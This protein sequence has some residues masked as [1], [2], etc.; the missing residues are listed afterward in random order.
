[1]KDVLLI[2]NQEYANL[3]IIASII[4]RLASDGC[5]IHCLADSNSASLLRFQDKCTV[6]DINN[7]TKVKYNCAI[8]FSPTKYA[9]EIIENVNAKSKLGYKYTDNIVDFYNEGADI[10]YRAKYIGIPT[11]ANLLQLVFGLADL[12]WQ[13]EGYTLQYFPRNRAKKSM[14]GIAVKDLYTRRFINSN[15]KINKLWQIPFKCNMIKQIDEI[16]RC[17]SIITD[18]EVVLYSS[19]ALRKQVEYIATRPVPYKIE[20][21]GSGNIHLFDKIESYDV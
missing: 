6:E 13:G 4:K 14:I 7:G 18:S 17:K 1:M 11:D 20:F 8:N 12:T 19:L 2:T 16:N 15:L 9:C 10:H 5:R 21:F 3:F